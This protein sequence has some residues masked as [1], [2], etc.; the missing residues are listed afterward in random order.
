MW[1][2]IQSV[3][4]VFSF[5]TSQTNSDTITINTRS[6][7]RSPDSEYSV[8]YKVS[9]DGSILVQTYFHKGVRDTA[10]LPRFGMRLVMPS[11]FENMEWF[12]RG[13]FESYS[14]R[15]TAAFIDLY[16]GK[17]ADQYVAYVIPEENG[18]KTDVRYAQW[19]D[20]RGIGLRV[21]GTE[22]LNVSA[23]H[24]YTSDLEQAATMNEIPW[25]NITEI[26]IDAA[27]MGLGSDQSWGAYPH[28]Q[29]R[30]LSDTFSYSFT[31]KPVGS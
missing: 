3:R 7:F 25:R 26:H 22:P 4:N 12:G 24:F 9:G 1:K 29:Y 30:L 8:T 15:K 11:S 23:H 28:D 13:P 14:D 19:T 5:E 2:D 16:Q 6:R 18:N 31:L 10:E 27:Q 20:N 17:V 21:T